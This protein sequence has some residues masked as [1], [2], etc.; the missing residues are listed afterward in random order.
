MLRDYQK[1]AIDQLYEWFN[2]HPI[3]NPCLVLPTG[4]GKSHI[5][6][7]LCKDAVKSW[8]GTKVL[9]MSHVAELI[10]QNAEKMLQHWPNA[11]LGIYTAGLGRR[12]LGEAITFGGIQSLRQKGDLIGHIDI[13]IIDEC[14]LISHKDEGGYRSLLA[15]LK[16]INPHLRVIGLTATPW[17]LGHGLICDGDAIFSDLIEPVTIEELIFKG[18]LAPL[19]SKF[20]DHCLDVSAVA[21]R[22]GEFIP[23]QLAKAVDSDDD[24]NKIVS[25][26]LTRASHCRSILVFG[27]GVA[28]SDHL[29]QAFSDAGLS[30]ACITGK[31]SKGE[32]ADL[33]RQFKAG[34]LRVLTNAEVL[35]AGFDAPN[36]DCLVIA[37]PTMSPVLYVQIAGRGMR[38][39][40][41]TDHCLVLDF[42]GN[43]QR[44]GP[45]TSV[46]P[47]KAKGKGSG[48]AP[49]KAC[50]E[51]G[52]A[53][54]LSVKLCPDCGYL[55]PIE[56][57]KKEWRLYQD[58][59]MGIKPMDMDV[60]DWAWRVHR[61]YNSG[62]EMIM[63]TY[64]HGFTHSIKE[65]LTVEHEGFAGRMGVQKLADIATEVDAQLVNCNDM[66]DICDLMQA[67]PCPAIVS[68]RKKGKLDDI[69]KREWK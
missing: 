24:V 30:A 68:Y 20:T 14:H 45:I 42:A 34:E 15:S 25:E 44:H 33:I 58:D 48:E 40:E 52:E 4:S 41:H 38:L 67:K 43:V 16:E 10:E 11:P 9:M 19:R 51:C 21:K 7:A 62:K 53:V 12:D 64:Y 37:R 54:H 69:I 27:T 29:A 36:T 22:G 6:A 26:T 1:R 56:E 55:W 49:I 32:R 18:Y 3:G 57:V 35:T 31:T 60:T 39:K 63:V 5:V 23:G 8:P 46:H 65:Y 13:A 66:Q 47:P 59:I 50:P 17:R 2:S 61:G 28:H